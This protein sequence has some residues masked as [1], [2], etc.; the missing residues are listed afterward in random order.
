MEK[1]LVINSLLSLIMK[2]FPFSS[3]SHF[4]QSFTFTDVINVLIVA[5]LLVSVESIRNKKIVEL[6]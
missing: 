1:R 5:L 6:D 4:L 3:L 2:N